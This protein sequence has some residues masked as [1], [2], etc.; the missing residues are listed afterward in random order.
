MLAKDRLSVCSIFVCSANGCR[1]REISSAL[2][3][4]L[5]WRQS[6]PCSV[7]TSMTELLHSSSQLSINSVLLQR[8]GQS[9]M[10]VLA[11]FSISFCVSTDDTRMLWMMLRILLIM[12]MSDGCLSTTLTTSW[13]ICAIHGKRWKVTMTMSL[14]PFYGA[15][16]VPSVTRCHCC[17]CCGHRFYIAIHQVS[18][19]SHAAC[20]IAIAG[21]GSSW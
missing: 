20:A 18:L 3:H 13:I 21:F 17:C 15:M 8:V 14:G 10:T 19:L 4:S 16:A 12:F 5:F 7:N 9:V 2:S 6:Q 1:R 11:H